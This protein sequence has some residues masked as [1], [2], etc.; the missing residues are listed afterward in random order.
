MKILTIKEDTNCFDDSFIKEVIFD[1]P[2]SKEFIDFLGEIG[3]LQYFPDFPRPFFKVDCP[4]RFILKGVE[5]SLKAQLILYRKN[6]E[7]L[8]QYFEESIQRYSSKAKPNLNINVEI[9]DSSSSFNE[10]SK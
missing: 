7:S 10:S 3:E 8:Q 1:Q 5:G 6:I 4:E 2:I 9:N